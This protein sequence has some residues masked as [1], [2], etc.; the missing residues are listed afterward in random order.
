MP[1]RPA[2]LTQSENTSK[3]HQHNQH[4]TGKLRHKNSQTLLF[5]R[6]SMGYLQ[7]DRFYCPAQVDGSRALKCGRCELESLL[8]AAKKDDEPTRDQ[9][10]RPQQTNLGMS[11][12]HL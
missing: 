4:N 3:G 10:Q 5:N 2:K 6:L 9:L 8:S 11:Y 12:E 7:N 1:L